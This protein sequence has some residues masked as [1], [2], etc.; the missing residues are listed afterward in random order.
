MVLTDK[1][2]STGLAPR[3]NPAHFFVPCEALIP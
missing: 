1:E 2:T 3:D